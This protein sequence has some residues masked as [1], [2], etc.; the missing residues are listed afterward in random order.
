MLH[1]STQQKTQVNKITTL[2]L[3][4]NW[5]EIWISI[6]YLYSV[7]CNRIRHNCCCCCRFWLIIQIMYSPANRVFSFSKCGGGGT[8]LIACTPCTLQL[9]ET[10][11]FYMQ[12]TLGVITIIWVKKMTKLCFIFSHLMLYCLFYFSSEIM[13]CVSSYQMKDWTEWNIDWSVTRRKLSLQK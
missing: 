7:I 6:Y 12:C 9:P 3:K 1:S 10:N 13:C 5:T 8:I 2:L 4:E 11:T